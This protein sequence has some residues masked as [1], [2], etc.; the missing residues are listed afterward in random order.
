MRKNHNGGELVGTYCGNEVPSLLD[1]TDK[2]WI[3]YRTDSLNPNFG[4]LAEYCYLTHSD[5][6]GKTGIIESPVYP[7]I[8][9][10]MESL[11]YRI[12]VKHGAVIRLEF[13]QLLMRTFYEDECES[14]LRI[15]NGYDDSAPALSTDLCFPNPEPII[16]DTNVVFIEFYQNSFRGVRFQIQWTEVDKSTLVNNTIESECGQVISLNNETIITNITSPGYPHG[17]APNMNCTWIISSGLPSYHPVI[18]FTDVNFEESSDCVTDYV[19]VASDRDDGSWKHLDKLCS[20]DLRHPRAFSGTPNLKIDFIS[21]YHMN[22]TG[23]IATTV[24]ECGG[25]MTESDG[26]IEHNVQNTFL[27]PRS[28][29]QLIHDCYWNITVRSGRT[30]QFEFL[31]M[32]L[33]NISGECLVLVSIRNGIDESSPYLGE[34]RFC[35][36]EKPVDIPQTSSNKA[37]V[38]FSSKQLVMGDFSLRYSEVKKECGGEIRL[39][40]NY[41]STVINSPN[42]PSVSDAHVECFWSIMAPVGERIRIDF[43]GRFDLTTTK[44][45]DKEYV[46]LRDG[47][48][49]RAQMIGVFCDKKP[50]TQFSKS[51]VLRVKYF[52][53]TDAPKNGFKVNISIATC[54]GMQRAAMGYVVSPGYP[55]VGAYPSNASCEYR[56]SGPPNTLFNLSFTE[57]DLPASSELNI[58]DQTKDHVKIQ[59]IIPDLNSTGTEN[60]LDIGIYCDNDPPPAILSDTNEILVT[61]KTFKKN[62]NLRGFKLFYNSSKIEC[63]GTVSADSGVITSPGYPSQNLNKVFCE[64]KIT[65]PKGRRVKA[66]FLDVDFIATGNQYLQRVGIYSDFRYSSRLIFVNRDTNPG[67]V[68]SSDNTMM[69]ALWIRMSSSNKGFKLKFSSD[70]ETIC[71]GDLNQNEGTIVPPITIN[72]TVFTCDYIRSLDPLQTDSL[73]KGTIA[74]YFKD[75]QVGKRTTSNCRFSAS[76]VNLLRMSGEDDNQKYL[77]RICGNLSSTAVVLSPFPDVKMEIR[78]SPFSGPVNFTLDYKTHPCGGIIKSGSMNILKNVALNVTNYGVLDCA[79]FVEYGDG[80]NILIN[81]KNLSLNL[82]CSKEY[83]KIYNGPTQMSPVIGKYCGNVLPDPT[84]YSQTN[85]IF[86]EYHTDNYN[87]GAEANSKNSSYELVTDISAFGCGGILNRYSHEIKSPMYGQQ[88]PNQLECIWEIRGD[89]GYHIGLTFSGRYFIEDSKNCS[90]DYLEIYDYKESNWTLLGRHC[91]RNL[92]PIYN[93]TAEKMKIIFRSDEST[94]GDGFS[95]EWQQNCGGVLVVDGKKRILSSPGYPRSYGNMLVCNY[96]FVAEDPTKFINLNF[97]DFNVETIGSRCMYDNITIYKLIDW[98]IPATYEKHGVYCGMKAPEKLRFKQKAVIVFRSDRW[99][100]KRGFQ[101]EYSVDQCGGDIKNSTMIS[102]ISDETSSG[103][104]GSHN[105]VWN[106]TAP[107]DKKIVIRFESF[108][109]EHSD[110]CIFDYVEIFNGHLLK[111]DQRLAKLCGNLTNSLRPIVIQNNLAVI[112]YKTD[113][114]NNLPGF[115]A[116]IMFKQKCDMEIVL[117]PDSN[118]FVLDKTEPDNLESER[119]CIYKV[120][121][122]PMSTIKMEL[123]AMH[124][125][126]CP[127]IR[128]KTACE[129]DYLEVLDGNGP[130]SNAIARYCGYDLPIPIISTNPALYVR[131]VTEPATIGVST[132]FKIQFTAVESVCGMEPHRNITE[133]TAFMSPGYSLGK[134]SSSTYPP[135]VRCTWIAEASP[136]KILEFEFL[137]FELEQDDNCTRDRL[138]I[139]DSVVKDVVTE[140][141][142]QDLV[143]RGK[144]HYSERPN[145][146]TGINGPVSSHIYCGSGIPHQYVSQTNKVKITFQSDSENQFKGFNIKVSVVKACSRNFTSLQGRVLS[147]HDMEDCKMTITVPD[148]YTIAIFFFKFFFYEQDC[149]KSSMKF[150]DGDFKDGVLMRTICGYNTPDPLFSNTSQI[151]IHSKFD[152]TTSFYTKGNYDLMYVASDRGR[153]CGGEIY[154][155]GGIFSSPLYPETNI[156][157]VN[158]NCTWTVSVPQ[159]L[160]VA[161]RFQGRIYVHFVFLKIF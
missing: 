123:L 158:T 37:F 72:N 35:G 53:D 100:E 117:T 153:G 28:S 62:S 137:D 63:G 108:S 55:G 19:S 10:S 145:F 41:K 40:S 32:N 87:I 136:M 52:T 154:N 133:D 61:L 124:M 91:G 131:Y 47:S 127:S 130:F 48:T 81:F 78:Q 73:M 134:L 17:Y 141:L 112:Q 88:Y 42:Y 104:A 20:I 44:D 109:L 129:C 71:A 7:K 56:I 102:T 152:N 90:K 23:F 149:E 21:D 14:F 49:A 12:M 1:A 110:Y 132:G 107:S 77:D 2:Y 93:A 34:G 59:S 80:F 76:V 157:R 26:I 118:M 89:P 116:A 18:I 25:I 74:F 98:M 51:N 86:I 15:Y 16:S 3:K 139:E 70:E 33:R 64:W 66:E 119:E 103:E 68:Y 46:E 38:K 84:I 45:C 147:S 9:L 39:K 96:T 6:Q 83:I 156:E 128:N 29:N 22:E 99:I 5:L 75:L 122:P 8:L 85:K 92:P 115:T 58:C 126:T 144:N 4:F 106:I 27:K 105:C 161:L 13:P 67:I 140:G 142:G 155:Y 101:L 125:S 69:V 159:N 31:S 95:A 114:S 11:T 148:N 36:T 30:I 24:L 43:I 113:Q 150:Y 57:I 160:K 111:E 54:G 143:Y 50:T 135:N 82:P 138:I 94:V 120:L 65:V 97:L 60:L 151:S 79:W 121:A 146:Y